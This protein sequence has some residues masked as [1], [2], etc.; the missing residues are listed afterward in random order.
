MPL[1]VHT[2]SRPDVGVGDAALY[3][4][5]TNTLKRNYHYG[6]KEK[7]KEERK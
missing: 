7:G 1:R 4:P 5:K 3:G 6:R 2:V